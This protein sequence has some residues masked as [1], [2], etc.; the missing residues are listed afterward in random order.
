MIKIWATTNVIA[1]LVRFVNNAGTLLVKPF[2]VNRAARFSRRSR[3]NQAARANQPLLWHHSALSFPRLLMWHHLSPI[4]P[5]PKTS[6]PPLGHWYRLLLANAK[7]SSTSPAFNQQR[8]HA[9]RVI[10]RRQ[11]PRCPSAPEVRPEQLE[12]SII[13]NPISP[14]LTPHSTRLALAS[15]SCAPRAGPATFVPNGNLRGKTYELPIA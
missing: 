4:S 5:P 6:L 9:A 2:I 7:R 13:L 3:A 11:L 15:R 1:R 10:A 12:R 14:W 8:H